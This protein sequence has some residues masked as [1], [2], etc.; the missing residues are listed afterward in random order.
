MSALVNNLLDMA[1]IESGEVKLHR[2]WQAFEEVVGSAL[3]PRSPRSPTTRRGR[4]ARDLPLVEFDATLIERV[5]YNLVENA[6]KYTPPGTDR[7]R[8]RRSSR[9]QAG[10]Q[11]ERHRP[12]IPKGQEEA[13]FEKFSRGASEST[14]PGV[15]LGLA[16]SRAIVDAH[17]G[18]IWAENARRRRRFTFMLPLG[19]PPVTPEEAQAV[20]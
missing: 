3:M 15:G 10:G 19:T 9:G 6:G 5:L 12:G 2:Q 18:T 16:I 11:R 1:R 17:R 20:L 8:H 14:T 13:I 7:H 4:R